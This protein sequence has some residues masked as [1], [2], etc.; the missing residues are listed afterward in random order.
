MKPMA[1]SLSDDVELFKLV[2]DSNWAFSAKLDGKRSLVRL[3]PGSLLR[4][5]TRSG[6]PQNLP[7]AII[8]ALGLVPNV[9]TLILDGELMHS[10]NYRVFDLVALDYEN[11]VIGPD[12][13]AYL[14]QI[15][16]EAFLL[17]TFGGTGPIS[18]VEYAYDSADKLNLWKYVLEHGGEGV[19]AR[20]QASE[21]KFGTTSFWW[22][23]WKVRQ[24]VDCVVIDKNLKGKANLLLGLYQGGKLVPVGK[25]SALTGEGPDVQPGD[26]VTVS[27]QSFSPSGKLVSASHPVRYPEKHP[28]ECLMS[29]V[30]P[31]NL[32]SIEGGWG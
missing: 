2:Y 9:T 14:R 11:K 30:V 6:D 4:A 28:E 23:K 19:V 15:A 29:Q 10:G 7:P 18:T 21:Y 22:R 5:Y 17:N 16:L 27:Y 24:T 3:G 20:H 1:L 31:I 32:H 12:H 13:P 26:V 8:K 25:V